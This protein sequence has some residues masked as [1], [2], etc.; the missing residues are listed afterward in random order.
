VTQTKF[1]HDS[2]TKFLNLIAVKKQLQDKTLES[3]I[4]VFVLIFVIIYPLFSEVIRRCKHIYLSATGGTYRHTHTSMG[5][6]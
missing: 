3:N 4:I 1:E 5:I 6:R 2:S